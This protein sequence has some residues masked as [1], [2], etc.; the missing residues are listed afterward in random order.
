MQCKQR[1]LVPPPDNFF[2]IQRD[3]LG[4]RR[5]F[6]ICL[7][8]KLVNEAVLAFK[9]EHCPVGFN[10]KKCIRPTMSHISNRAL[11]PDGYTLARVATEAKG[12][13]L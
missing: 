1:L 11:N 3:K 4:K 12:C 13:A 7:L 8:T 10:T 6:M 9:T 5:A 2:N